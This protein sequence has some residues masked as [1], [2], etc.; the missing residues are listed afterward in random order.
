MTLNKNPDFVSNNPGAFD[1]Y[2]G[3]NSVRVYHLP[4]DKKSGSY[5]QTKKPRYWVETDSG[6]CSVVSKHSTGLYNPP[7]PVPTLNNL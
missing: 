2:F 7:K 5:L 1:A 3:L 6:T 4:I